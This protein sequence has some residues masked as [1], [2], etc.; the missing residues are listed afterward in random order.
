MDILIEGL[1]AA[2]E[3]DGAWRDFDMPPGLSDAWVTAYVLAALGEVENQSTLD[4][5]I[6]FLAQ[7]A[8]KN[9]GWGYNYRTPADAD[10]TAW[11]L[12]AAA[13]Q[14]P[15]QY[16]ERGISFLL[17]HQC[18]DGGFTTY[19]GPVSDLWSTSHPDVTPTIVRA[20][21]RSKGP[22]TVIEDGLQVVSRAQRY[23]GLWPSFWWCTPL[24]A[25]WESVILLDEAGIE[26]H[27]QEI[28]NTVRDPKW[29]QRTFDLIF[30]FALARRL[31][32][33]EEMEMYLVE[34]ESRI[35]FQTGLMPGERILQLPKKNG[36]IPSTFADPFGIFTSATALRC[37]K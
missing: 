8:R 24:Y 11:V 19:R 10:S 17:S 18:D 31:N 37:L 26:W 36:G 3:E 34:L 33:T 22:S 12:L 30:S 21:L 14:L 16:V 29:Q 27:Q 23:D 25:T 35:D 13:D 20:L 4:N 28:L 15:A 5:A 32:L 9:G 1:V 6:A 7:A 2:Q